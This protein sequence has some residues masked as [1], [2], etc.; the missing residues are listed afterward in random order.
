MPQIWFDS[1]VVGTLGSLNSFSGDEENERATPALVA[2]YN[3]LARALRSSNTFSIRPVG[4]DYVSPTR[5]A[6]ALS[7]ARFENNEVV[8]L[9]LRHGGF[10]EDERP[11]EFEDLVVTTASVVVASRTD[12]GIQRASRLAVVPYGDGELRI[13]RP[14]VDGKQAE[15][16]EHSWGDRAEKK[17]GVSVEKGKLVIPLRERTEQ[18][19]PVEWIEVSI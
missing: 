13:R 18:G 8:L 11:V 7:W 16:I 5:G 3:G 6:R 15:I 1:A 17:A 19:L 10:L 4:A 14:G 2:K 12:E 9:A